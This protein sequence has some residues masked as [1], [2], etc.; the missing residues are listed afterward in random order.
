MAASARAITIKLESNMSLLQHVT[1]DKNMHGHQIQ[2]RL[3]LPVTGAVS[4]HRPVECS[5]LTVMN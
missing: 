4:F 2:I 3:N 1:A 5:R